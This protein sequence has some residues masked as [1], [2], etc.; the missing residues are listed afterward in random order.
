MKNVDQDGAKNLL[1]KPLMPEFSE[2]IRKIRNSLMF[3]SFIGL[4]IVLAGVK[5]GKDSTF[6][7]LKLENLSDEKILLGFLIVNTYSLFHF[8]WAS[9]DYFGE[10][11]VRLT[12]CRPGLIGG[13][14]EEG[15]DIAEDPRNSTL[16]NWWLSK[17]ATVEQIQKDSEQIA[18][19]QSDIRDQISQLKDTPDKSLGGM[20]LNSANQQLG[21]IIG[22]QKKTI[23]LLEDKRI[24]TS[25]ARFDRWYFFLRSSQ[26]ARWILIELGLPLILGISACFLL[27][28]ELFNYEDV[29]PVATAKIQFKNV[30]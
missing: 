5:L 7:G 18:S 1:G 27:G 28:K 2:Y 21:T 11:R 14:V 25:L 26:G 16:Y 30:P 19:M 29:K 13:F 17:L 8:A 3:F 22:Y 9:M 24:S 6:L 4:A 15:G 20:N 10:W 23:S 12:G